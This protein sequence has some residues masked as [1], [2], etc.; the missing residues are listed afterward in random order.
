LAWFEQNGAV[1][2]L[3][4]RQ[5]AAA[6][7]P[8]RGTG[9]SLMHPPIARSR[10]SR[11]RKAAEGQG[12][13]RIVVTGA[14]G[15]IG[16]ALCRRLAERGHGV[17]GLTRHAAEP[18]AGVELCP[19]GDIGPSTDWSA[20]LCGIEVVVHLANRAHRKKIDPSAAREADAAAA[21]AQAAAAAGVRRLVHM[22][23]IR[24]MGEASQPGRPFHADDA[25]RPQDPYGRGKLATEGALSAAA[26]RSALELVILRPPLVYGPGV[27][28]NF[29][30]LIRLAASGL[31]L[32]FAAID[33]RRSLIFIDN[34]GDLAAQACIHPAAAG[35]I[36]LAGDGTDL[37]TPELLRALADGLGRPAR[38]YAVP[39]MAFAMLR[40]LPGL[41][42]LVA[43]LTLSLEVDDSV[44]RDAL[45][46]R[47][48][49][50]PA[51]ALAATAA[52]FRRRQ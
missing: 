24:A 29:R 43:R 21:L 31:P 42:P 19:I 48:K 33:N 38:L 26:R 47:P 39:D 27:K 37:S 16:R 51:E 41:G 11:L 3:G 35:R 9:S 30:A 1:S 18:I 40:A 34:L 6:A 23:S 45:G 13:M 50:G 17:F 20:R 2:G 49:I 44:T 46:W 52:A 28:A 22:S 8:C 32:P 14:A 10:Y 25:P 36:W 5:A 4:S 15:F 7:P 12:P